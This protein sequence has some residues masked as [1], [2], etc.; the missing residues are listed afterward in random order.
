MTPSG[1]LDRL[2]LEDLSEAGEKLTPKR[3][4][5][6]GK[7]QDARRALHSSVPENLPG[8]EKELAEL[9]EF[10]LENLKSQSSGSL[11][12]S[13]PPGTGKTASLSK[14]MKEKEFADSFQKVYV[15]CTSMKSAGTI[16]SKIIQEL[17]VQCPKSGKNS[18]STIEKYLVKSHKMILLILDELDQLES[19]RQSV[20]Y[21]I[22]EWP[23][24]A[25]SKLILVG[26]ANALD[27][28]D[29]ILP[30]LQARCELK[31]KLMHFAPYDKRQI[32]EIIEQ[33]LSQANVSDVFTKTAI[34]LLA[35]KVAAISGD[36]RRAL[37]ISRRVVELAESEK[38]TQVLKPN[39][40]NGKQ[41]F[42]W[43]KSL[44]GIA[45]PEFSFKI[46]GFSGTRVNAMYNEILFVKLM[47]K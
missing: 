27:L 46:H 4:F 39:V 41:L 45:R 34:Q 40:D 7:Y 23:S 30:R 28:T 33:R 20:L 13:G 6:S 1:L 5:A 12:V 37:D 19:T 17:G 15:N 47:Q 26:I 11:Y 2:N 38:T 43:P 42:L 10:L 16:Y 9:R 31:P 14:I 21:S 36:V 8:R 44:P 3:L 35:G 25:N 32:S 29:R 22:F 24:I 18:K